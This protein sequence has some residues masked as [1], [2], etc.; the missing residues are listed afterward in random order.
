MG[1]YNLNLGVLHIQSLCVE[2]EVTED[3]N[4]RQECPV[5]DRGPRLYCDSSRALE[6]LFNVLVNP[7]RYLAERL[8]VFM[9]RIGSIHKDVNHTLPLIII[10][11]RASNYLGWR[12]HPTFGFT[13][14]VSQGGS[15]I[16]AP[17]NC[18]APAGFRF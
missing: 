15:E 3:R 18:L 7:R 2:Q 12:R 16:A 13:A 6:V 4:R 5:Q 14:I 9:M 17:A 10:N 8:S 1:W 11:V